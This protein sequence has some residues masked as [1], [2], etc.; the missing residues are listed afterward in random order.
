MYKYCT[1]TYSGIGFITHED[2]ESCSP[3]SFPANVYAPGKKCPL[4]KW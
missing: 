4:G 3:Q 1:A 2:A